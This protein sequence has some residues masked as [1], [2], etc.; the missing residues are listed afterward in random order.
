MRPHLMEGRAPIS[1]AMA[2]AMS[3]AVAMFFAT[4]TG[5]SNH[6]GQLQSTPAAISDDHLRQ[7]QTMN[8]ITSDSCCICWEPP[9]VKW[10]IVLLLLSV[11]RVS[12]AIFLIYYQLLLVF[13]GAITRYQ[14]CYYGKF[15]EPT[16]RYYM[17]LRHCHP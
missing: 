17:I 10:R 13:R 6:F 1:M 12:G 4:A 2:C 9:E 5:I 11:L 8:P 3:M 14:G 15:Q 16:T 7:L